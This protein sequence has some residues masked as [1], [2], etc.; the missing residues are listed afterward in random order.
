MTEGDRVRVGLR[1][2]GLEFDVIRPIGEAPSELE[3]PRAAAGS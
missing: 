3:E 2:G 1:D